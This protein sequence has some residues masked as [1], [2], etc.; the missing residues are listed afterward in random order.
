MVGRVIKARAFGQQAGFGQQRLGALVA[1]F[2]QHH[3]MRL[4][5]RG[6]ITWV[7][8]AFAG[9]RVGF[10]DLLL[11]VRRDRID[12]EIE[13]S[14]VFGLAADDERRAGFVDQDGVDLVDD[15]VVERPL[16]AVDHLGDHVVAQVVEAELVVGAVGDVG[17]VGS[18]LLG[19]RHLRGVDAHGQAEE[20]VEAAHPFGVASGEVFVD[21]HQMHAP[22]PTRH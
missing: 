10:A 20:V 16:H 5:V 11:Q 22:C 8:H 17:V 13:L 19:P 21:R 7:D 4:L 14:L 15:A 18:L 6:E 12:L 9:A 3:L 1:G 2:G